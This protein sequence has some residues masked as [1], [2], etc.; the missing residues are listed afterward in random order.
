M[1]DLYPA[2]HVE[3]LDENSGKEEHHPKKLLKRITALNHEED[4]L[5]FRRALPHRPTLSISK[6]HVLRALR[7][8]QKRSESSSLFSF[9]RVP[10]P[11]PSP[12][13]SDNFPKVEIAC[14]EAATYYSVIRFQ[15]ANGGVSATYVRVR[16]SMARRFF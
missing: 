13:P 11:C 6:K 14:D 12:P 5:D 2:P 3:S 15:P 10:V 9:A 1:R 4:C 16:C 7:R 8:S